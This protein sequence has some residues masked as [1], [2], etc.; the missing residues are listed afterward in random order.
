MV[1]IW[2]A[3]STSGD[4]TNFIRLIMPLLVMT[5]VAFVAW[6]ALT[7][8]IFQRAAERKRRQREGLAPLPS[9]YSQAW[10]WTKK[11]FEPPD[12]PTPS[13][14]DE[15][16]IP[17]ME[18]LMA[19][20]PTPDMDALL[21]PT[22]PPFSAAPPPQPAIPARAM[23]SVSQSIPMP[24]P[25]PNPIPA[26][27]SPE[28]I[29][30]AVEVMRILRDLD[31]GQLII[32][33]RGE[34]FSHPQQLAHEKNRRRF[35]SLVQELQHLIAAPAPTPAAPKVQAASPNPTPPLGIADQIEA[36]LQERLLLHAP[37][38]HRH[39]HILSDDGGGVKIEVDDQVYDSI[40]DI[41]E[42]PV[43]EFLESVMQ[44]WSGQQ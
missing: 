1:A 24:T 32:D 19:N 26:P 36:F 23:T 31:G 40:Q 33:L 38:A 15:S 21:A 18:N 35:E 20:L 17:D 41:P 43:R 10:Q 14:Q 22:P 42:T 7:Y 28:A 12:S 5:A 6:V 25:S 13:F 9:F 44:A 39:L 8:L 4:S 11:Q 2:I 30:D 34:F 29:E 37:L 3:Q 27:P 16:L